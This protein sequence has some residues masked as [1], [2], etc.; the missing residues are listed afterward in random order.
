MIHNHPILS[1]LVLTLAV[2]FIVSCTTAPPPDTSA[3]DSLA[4]EA[5]SKRWVDAFNQ[6]DATAV[7]SLYTE[8]ATLLEPNSPL[9]VGRENIQAML[10]GF[11]DTNDLK[12]QLTVIE[13]SVNGDMAHKVGKYTLTIQ[14][15]EGEAITD[16]GKYVE[17]W[18]RENGSWKMDVDIWNSSLPL[19]VAEEEAIEEAEEE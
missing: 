4:I 1:L 18:K 9:V 7:A 10:Q 5:V 16:N 8:E 17:I 3:E 11:F 14:P 2:P 13:L 19:P 6:G 15:E 12:L